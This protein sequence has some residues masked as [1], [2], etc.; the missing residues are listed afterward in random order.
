MEHPD[1]KHTTSG[2]ASEKT[3]YPRYR[4]AWRMIT[5]GIMGHGRW[6]ADRALISQW[7]THANPKYSD[8]Q[9]WV[10]AESEINQ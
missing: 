4:V 2:T 9:H 1:V 10:Q 3:A 5:T 8:M 6:S 7:V